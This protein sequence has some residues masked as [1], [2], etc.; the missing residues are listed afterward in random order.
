MDI[1]LQFKYASEYEKIKETVTTAFASL[2][3]ILKEPAL[4]IGVSKLSSDNYSVM[5]NTWI[6]AHGFEDGRLLIN[7]KLMAELKKAG[8]IGG[9]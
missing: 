7:E 4:R 2:N 8:V 9:S 1:E 6:P 3:N 5:I